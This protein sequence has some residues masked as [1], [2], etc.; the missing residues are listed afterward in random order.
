[1]IEHVLVALD[2]QTRVSS[3]PVAVGSRR[4]SAIL[5]VA[6]VFGGNVST[7]TNTVSGLPRVSVTLNRICHS[8]FSGRITWPVPLG[9]NVCTFMRKVSDVSAQVVNGSPM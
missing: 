1:M 2:E 4:P 3:V 8:L 5:G 9:S 6:G 7:D